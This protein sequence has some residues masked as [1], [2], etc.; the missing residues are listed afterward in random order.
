MYYCHGGSNQKWRIGNINPTPE[1]N[2]E[3]ASKTNTAFVLDVKGANPDN[4]AKLQLYSRNDTIAQRWKFNVLTGEIK[5]LTTKCLD[6][7]S[8]I[9]GQDVRIND[10]NGQPQQQWEL[11]A[12]SQLVNKSKGQCM[13]SFNGNKLESR[14][15]VG[16][17]HE[18]NNQKWIIT[19]P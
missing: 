10:C 6:A 5:G 2:S 15:Y 13:D 17:C 12:N 19:N 18:G 11:N 1:L 16:V 7:G 9:G 8:G 3:I 14:L 4:Q